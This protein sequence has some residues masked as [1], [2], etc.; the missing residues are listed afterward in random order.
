MDKKIVKHGN[1][2]LNDDY[3]GYMYNLNYSKSY[4]FNSH[5]HKCFELV[6]ILKGNLIYIVENSEYVLSDGDFIMTNPNEMHSFSFPQECEYRREFLHIYPGFLEKYP[7]ILKNMT[8]RKVGYFNRIDADM[9][10]KHNIDKIFEGIR[11]YC[12]N[13]VE[14]TDFM[15]LTY[16]LQLMI[17]LNRII[18]T[19]T[20]K[21]QTFTTNKKANVIRRY[22]DSYY[23][24]DI[25]LDILSKHTYMSPSHV[26]RIFKKETGMNI[27]SYLTLRRITHAKNLIM[28]GRK[29]MNIFSLCGFK[30]YSTF[31]RAFIKYVGMSP[32]DF[33]KEQNKIISPIGNNMHE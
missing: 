33:K 1:H 3:N 20:P 8:D 14:E 32:E 18:L 4:S 17:K 15:V 10:K 29:V 16:T 31:Y 30:D 23:M 7:N 22:I 21:K 27:K 2:I 6:H 5:M 19:E 24:N 28:E 26:S 12:E 13:P 25:T 11:E 9:V